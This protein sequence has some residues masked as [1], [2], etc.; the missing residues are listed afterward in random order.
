M[1]YWGPDRHGVGY[2][3][4]SLGGINWSFGIHLIVWSII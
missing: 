3:E 2:L 4:I 1:P